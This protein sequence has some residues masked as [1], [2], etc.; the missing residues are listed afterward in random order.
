MEPNKYQIGGSHY[1]GEYQ[2]WDWVHDTRQPYVIGCATKY[3]SRWRKKNGLEDLRKSLHYISKAEDCGI[4]FPEHD[5]DN[6]VR[7]CNQLSNDDAN[8]ILYIA[9]NHFE[10]AIKCIQELIE[11]IECGPG[12]SYV[13]PDG[14]FF[15]G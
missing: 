14:G 6:T 2:H 7:F 10:S 1:Q 9:F 12:K 13:D 11:E 15:K 8:I 5:A 3:V 4:E